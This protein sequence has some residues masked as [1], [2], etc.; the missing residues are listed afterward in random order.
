[1][2]TFTKSDICKILLELVEKRTFCEQRNEYVVPQEVIMNK[3]TSLYIDQ[4]NDMIGVDNN[5]NK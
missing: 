2:E 1:M 4:F 5:G 3:I